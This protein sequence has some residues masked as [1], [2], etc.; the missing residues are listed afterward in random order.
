MSV[1]YTVA[2]GNVVSDNAVH[3]ILDAINRINRYSHKI[4]QSIGDD[5]IDALLSTT[6][7]YESET[8][9]L[10]KVKNLYEVE[11]RT[12]EEFL[13]KHEEI[14]NV[15]ADV[16]SSVRKFFPKEILSVRYDEDFDAIHLVINIKDTNVEKNEKKYFALLDECSAKTSKPEAIIYIVHRYV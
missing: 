15:L 5:I 9:Y 13:S 16:Y 3:V 1:D 2:R 10:T 4:I 14:A 11:N 6:N 12:T 8:D 7:I